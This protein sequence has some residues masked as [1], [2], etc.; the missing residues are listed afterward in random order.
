MRGENAEG[1]GVI[2]FARKDDET[3]NFQNFRSAGREA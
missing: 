2:W 1:E 3:G